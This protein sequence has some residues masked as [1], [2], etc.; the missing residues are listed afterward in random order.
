MN[1]SKMVIDAD[2]HVNPPPVFWDEYLPSKFRGR[3]PQIEV[4]SA[5]EGHDWVVFEGARKPLSV[6]ASVAGQGSNH[7][8]LG[9]LAELDVGG[10]EPRRRL[11]DME[12][13]GVDTAV[14]F[15][16]GPLGSADN[17]LFLES[18]Q[19]YNRWLADFCSYDKKRLVGIG[20]IPM[21]DVDQSIAMLEDAAGRGVRGVNI[22]AF[23]MSPSG[24]KGGG[25]FAAQC[26]ALTGD[27][28]GPRQYD[29]PEFDRFWQA[30][31]DHDLAI[32]I[33]LG[34]RVARPDMVTPLVHSVMSKVAMAEPIA[35]L[36]FGGV[37]DRFPQ[38]RF[39]SIE[40][41]VGWM[42]WMAEYMDNFYRLHPKWATAKLREQPSYYMDHNIYGSFIRDSVGISLR[43]HKGG[44]NIMWSSDYP[45]SE[46]SW[47]NSGA[48]IERQF[49]GLSE[50]ERRPILFDNA[51]RFFGL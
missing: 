29:N 8:I 48:E 21:Q 15:G 5:S 36:I 14:L 39:G 41:G 32:T 18:F 30:A 38:L 17:E 49:A 37:F 24:N 12:T 51:R 45:H 40:S 11:N 22:P 4:G 20:Y 26:L 44:K 13:D 23:P 19:A 6:L 9:R 35:T 3:G 33:H 27:P 31:V 7:K 25:G 46:T 34:A 10:Y 28:D 50:S 42:A 1:T 16:G 47:P 2:A 43:H